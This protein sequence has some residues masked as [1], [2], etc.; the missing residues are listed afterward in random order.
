MKPTLKKA[1]FK[2]LRSMHFVGGG[3]GWGRGVNNTIELREMLQKD[4]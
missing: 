2:F 1:N 3:W 4:V